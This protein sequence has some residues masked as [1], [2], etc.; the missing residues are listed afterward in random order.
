VDVIMKKVVF[1]LFLSIAAGLALWSLILANA[2]AE[3]FKI[4]TYNVENLFDLTRDQTDYTDYRVGGKTGWNAAMLAKKLENIAAVIKDLDAEI[5]ALQEIE[6]KTALTL[7]QKTLDRTGA[8]YEYA[9][10]AEQVSAPVKCALLSRFPVLEK[11]EIAIGRSKA[12]HILKVTLDISGKPL[13]VYVNHWKSKS[14]P[15]SR[16]LE[17]AARL[18]REISSLPCDADFILI[19]DFNADYNEYETFK[20]IARLND[21]GGVTGI[22]HVIHTLKDGQLVDESVL[23]G[24]K[25]CDYLY[26]LWLE[27]P[28]R[29]RWSV[30]FFGRKNSPDSIIVPRAL[31]DAAGI[32]YVDNSFDKFDPD[33]LFEDNRVFRWQRADRGEGRH[34]GRGYSDHLPVF[35]RFSTAPFRGAD[36]SES[37]ARKPSGIMRIADL[38]DDPVDSLPVRIENAVVIYKHQDSAVIKQKNGRAVYVYKAAQKLAP[39]TAYDLSV[40]RL[41]RFYG[42][43]EVIG[44]EAVKSVKLVPAITKYFISG[45]GIDFSAPEFRNEVIDRVTGIYENAWLH[46]GDDRKIRLY[47]KDGV[48]APENFSRV[49]LRRVRIGYHGHPEIIVE[50]PEQIAVY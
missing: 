47:F 40:T 25:G 33:Y 9:V 42:N 19:G 11:K 31:Y 46:Y 2:H 26:N 45:E 41:K 3:P 43:L 32:S 4:A 44:I 5:V 8:H 28:E 22:N 16:R 37:V 7:L 38:Y 17:Y 18:A 23:T 35:A 12:R 14:G 49:A 6:S 10:I 36:I 34:L 30:N 27:M 13:V 20:D 24:Q 21:T 29:R 39:K 48:L 1:P 50:K 15:E